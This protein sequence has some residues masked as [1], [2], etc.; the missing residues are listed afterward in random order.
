MTRERRRESRTDRPVVLIVD[1]HHDVC[2]LYS[3]YLDGVGFAPCI[4][5]NSRSAFAWA[6]T[7]QPAAVVADLTML[8]ADRWMLLEQLNHDFRTSAIPVVVT[9]DH[10]RPVTQSAAEDPGC[11]AFLPKTCAPE[12]LGDTLRDVLFRRARPDAPGPTLQ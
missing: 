7:H 4:A 1:D 10:E 5:T 3:L 2:T 11:A 6:V 9:S 8:N 12:I